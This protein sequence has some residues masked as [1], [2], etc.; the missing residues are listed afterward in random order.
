MKKILVLLSALLLAASAGRAQQ[1]YFS[2]EELPDLIQA[3]PA[4]PDSLSHG[5]A[6]D[7]M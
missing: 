1:V 7:V 6:Y 5:F 2:T 4:P 3:L